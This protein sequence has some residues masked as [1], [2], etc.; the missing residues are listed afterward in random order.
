MDVRWGSGRVLGP[1][2][3]LLG[4]L[5]GL[6]G[7]HGGFLG[8]LRAN[9]RRLKAS[10]KRLGALGGLNLASWVGRPNGI[11]PVLAVLGG[12]LL[13]FHTE[14]SVG[15]PEYSGRVREYIRKNPSDK[16]STEYASNPHTPLL[17]STVADNL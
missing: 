4:L 1:L 13:V 5:G 16:Q 6:L 10:W 9:W 8:H 11:D 12:S 3:G 2:G 15:G 14:K 17:A 7:R